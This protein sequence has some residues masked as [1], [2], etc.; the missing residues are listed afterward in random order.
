[1]LVPTALQVPRSQNLRSG[2]TVQLSIQHAEGPR[3]ILHLAYKPLG[4]CSGHE[5]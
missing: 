1:M 5:F 4:K 3:R 2:A